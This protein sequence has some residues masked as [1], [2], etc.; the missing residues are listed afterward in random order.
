MAAKTGRLLNDC[1]ANDRKRLL[2]SEALAILRERLVPVT[3]TETAALAQACGR[4]CAVDVPATLNIP[5]T[6]NAAVDG[7]AFCAAD[8]GKNGGTLAV[9]YRI[10]A[11]DTRPIELEPGTAARIFTGATMPERADTVAMQEDCEADRD[12][13]SVTIP[14]GLE[15]GSNRRRAG[16]DAKVGDILC[17]KGAYLRPQEI[18]AAASTGVDR[19][20]VFRPLR[21]ALLS[22]GNEIREPGKMLEKGQFYDANRYLIATMLQ[23]LPASITDLGILADDARQVAETLTKAAATHEVILTS[24]GASKGEEDHF[25][26]VLGDVGTRHLWQLAVKPGRPMCFGQIGGCAVFALPGNP[27]AAFVCYLLYVR[28]ALVAMSGG[29]WPEPQRYP[30]PAGFRLENKKTGRR[31]FWRGWIE[32]EPGGDPVVRKFTRDGSGLITGL[33]SA[34]GLI[35]IDEETASVQPGDMVQFIPFEAFGL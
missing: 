20:D 28:P 10:T 31:E 17:R 9:R 26:R 16:E 19:I 30:L 13:A 33:R 34:T 6:D 25:A 2:H 11:G 15:P 18:A 21:V 14:G 5:A 8:L 22:S 23:S 1:F 3:G 4:L 35:E 27:V 24:G 7:Y 29:D 12:N 32:H